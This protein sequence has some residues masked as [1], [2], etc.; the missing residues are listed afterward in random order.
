ME[1]LIEIKQT[2][3]SSELEQIIALQK[4]NLYYQ[5]NVSE[6]VEEGFVTV[7]HDLQSL[8]LLHNSFPASIAVKENTVVGYALVMLPEFAESIRVLEPMFKLFNQITYRRKIITQYKYFVMGQICIDKSVRKQGLFRRL[9]QDLANRTLAAGYELMVTEVAKRNTRS[10]N[11]HI[12][13][14]FELVHI[15]TDPWDETWCVIVYALK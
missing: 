13:F 3:N 4:N 11:A 2:S 6:Q 12:A 15:Y 10:Y 9:Y 14:G 7:E 5:V 1:Y 8:Q